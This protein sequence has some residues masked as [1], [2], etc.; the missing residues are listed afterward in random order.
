MTKQYIFNGCLAGRLLWRAETADEIEQLLAVILIL[1]ADFL[2]VIVGDGEKH[3][4]IDLKK[5]V[6]A[7]CSSS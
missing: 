2:E 6:L 7:V 1:D 5:R 3:I 4:Q